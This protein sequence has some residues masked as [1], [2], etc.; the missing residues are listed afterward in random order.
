MKTQELRD[1]SAE[2]L[3]IELLNLMRE[4]FNL[5]IQAANKRLEKTHFLKQTRQNIARVKT[6]LTEKAVTK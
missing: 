6:V 4:Q 2:E 1:K 5:R 3:N